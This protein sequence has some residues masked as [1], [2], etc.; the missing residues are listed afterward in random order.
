[1][2]R[3]ADS[4]SDVRTALQSLLRERMVPVLEGGV[5][6]PFLPMI[7]AH[8]CRCANLQWCAARGSTHAAVGL[9]AKCIDANRTAWQQDSRTHAAHSWGGG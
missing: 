2:E 1:M 4:D 3:V 9:A 6:R 7:M 8:V 5:L